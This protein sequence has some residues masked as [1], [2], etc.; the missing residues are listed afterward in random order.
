MSMIARCDVCGGPVSVRQG[1]NLAEGR[2]YQC[3][4]SGHLGVGYSELNVFAEN[5]M[6]A[7]LT[8]PE[9]V[10]Q[11]VPTGDLGSKMEAARDAVITIRMELDDL[12]D[13]VGRGTLSANLA[14]RAEGGILARLREAEAVERQLATPSALHGLIEPGEDVARRWQSKP[15]AAKRE[16]ARI[17]FSPDMLGELRLLRAASRGH[18][19]PI[20]ER[21]RLRRPSH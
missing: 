18:H 3:H 14:A 9:N 15:I 4:R 1:K 16:I 8:H 6:L 19:Q 12:A 11:A 7:Y 13:Q 20:H 2:G 17:L 10:T 5:L 21:V